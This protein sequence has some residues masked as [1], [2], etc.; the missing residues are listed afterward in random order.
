ALASVQLIPNGIEQC[1][2]VGG[3]IV[4]IEV[5]VRGQKLVLQ[6]GKEHIQGY[7]PNEHKAPEAKPEAVAAPRPHHSIEQV[8]NARDKKDGVFL[9]EYP[10]AQRQAAKE[11][12][13]HL[14]PV[15]GRKIQAQKHPEHHQVIQEHLALVKD[16]QRGKI[17]EKRRNHGRESAFRETVCCLKQQEHAANVCDEH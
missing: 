15:A 6:R 10:D 12:H 11:W 1:H 9:C 17:K 2:V 3:R 14:T 5:E 4:E 8:G 16:G 7:E 13:E